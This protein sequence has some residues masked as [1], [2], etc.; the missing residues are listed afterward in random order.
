MEGEPFYHHSSQWTHF[1]GY[2][3]YQDDYWYNAD[4]DAPTKYQSKGRRWS[5]LPWTREQESSCK[6]FKVKLKATME[7]PQ[8]RKL[9]QS[10]DMKLTDGEGGQIEE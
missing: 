9:G 1:D 3:G 5:Y 8:E 7:E 10:Q 4:P 6:T 2:G